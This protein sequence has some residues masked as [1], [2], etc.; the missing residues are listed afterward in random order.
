MELTAPPDAEAIAVGYLNPELAARGDEARASTRVPNPRPARFVRVSLTG[1]TPRSV[2][3]A[4]AQVTIECWDTDSAA[5]AELARTV[6]ALMCAMDTPDGHVPQGPAGWV[7]G[8]V[9]LEDPT[10]GIP[11]Y[12]MT[13]IVRTRNATLPGGTP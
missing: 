8:P 11:R 2:A 1:T 10:A 4:D 3:H 6:Y 5:A 9:Y 7:G 13:P 12:V